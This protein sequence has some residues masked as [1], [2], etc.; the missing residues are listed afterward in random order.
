M[1]PSGLVE[2]HDSSLDVCSVLVTS[3][4]GGMVLKVVREFWSTAKRE[5]GK[6][7]ESGMQGLSSSKQERLGG[8]T[9]NF[10]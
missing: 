3:K 4:C 6:G 1:L 9:H 5:F 7:F 10:L 2:I 8:D